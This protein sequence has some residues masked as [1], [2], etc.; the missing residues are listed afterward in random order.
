CTQK[1]FFAIK[2]RK[3]STSIPKYRG[4][5]KNHG[6][7]VLK[8]DVLA[9]QSSR[10]QFYPASNV[11]CTDDRTLYALKDGQVFVTYES[12]DPKADSPLYEIV[13]RGCKITKPHFNILPKTEY[14]NLGGRFKLDT[15]T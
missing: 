9:T 2:G 7:M 8:N 10:L 3:K 15:L 12:L 14:E 6:E 4:I 11:G 1:A 13:K 5:K